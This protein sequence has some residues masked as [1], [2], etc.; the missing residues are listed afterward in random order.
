M[1][2][3]DIDDLYACRNLRQCCL[4][5]PCRKGGKQDVE[6]R[7]A[8]RVP[9]FHLQVAQAPKTRIALDQTLAD[10]PVTSRIDKLKRRMRC[11]EAQRLAAA[12]S[13]H[14]HNAYAQFHW[15]NSP[16]VSG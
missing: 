5:L 10:R 12:I 6:I 15:I 2:A 3:T 14:A 7:Q 9:L 1:I 8:H 16:D 11:T 4:G 13:A